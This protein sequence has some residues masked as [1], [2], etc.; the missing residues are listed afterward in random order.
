MVLKTKL[1]ADAKVIHLSEGS[2]ATKLSVL[3]RVM[4]SCLNFSSHFLSM[5]T[6][7]S[8]YFNSSSRKFNPECLFFSA[9]VETFSECLVSCYMGNR[10]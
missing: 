9:T 1:Q 3:V 2:I 4:K 7:D 10:T 5:S 8:Q 6:S